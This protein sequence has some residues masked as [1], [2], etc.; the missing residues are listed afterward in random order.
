M[1]GCGKRGWGS[2]GR[3]PSGW[4]NRGAISSRRGGLHSPPDSS[5]AGPPGPHVEE[6]WTSIRLKPYFSDFVIHDAYAYGFDGTILACIDVETG[7]RM[8]KGGRYG[9]GQLLLLPDQDVLL[10]VTEDGE[11]ALVAAAADGFA[12]LARI[13]AMDGKTWNHPVLVG[14][15]LL[16][17]NGQEMVAFRLTLVE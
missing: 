4:G 5:S 8:W 10:V 17:R 3:F 2:G 9:S 16:V 6:R 1:R 7:E 15:L 12:E 14:D 11:L 13:P